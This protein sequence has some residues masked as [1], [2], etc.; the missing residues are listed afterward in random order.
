MSD[1]DKSDKP[2]LLRDMTDAEIGALMSAKNE[3][4]VIERH[5]EYDFC[6]VCNP[7]W[8]EDCAYRVKSETKD[9]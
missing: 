7:H 3:G 1:C 9:N 2:K 6:F 5:Y 4:K 8:Y